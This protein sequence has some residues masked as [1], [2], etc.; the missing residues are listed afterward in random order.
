[1]EFWRNVEAASGIGWAYAWSLAGGV[2]LA[3]ILAAVRPATRSRLRIAV[4]LLL[5]SLGI[6]LISV[7]LLPQAV[8]GSGSFLFEIARF[9]AEI[10]FAL[11]WIEITS[12]FFFKLFLPSVGISTPPILFDAL[13]GFVYLAMLLLLLGMNG[14]NL[15]GLVATSAVLTGIIGFSMQDTLGNLVGGISLQAERTIT[16]G[17]WIR[18]GNVEGVIR[19]ARWRQTSIETRDGSMLVIPNTMLAKSSVTVLGRRHGQARFLLA[20]VSFAVDARLGPEAVIDLVSRA[21]VSA[22][23]PDVESTPPPVC[24]LT[25]FE[26]G[27][28][29][30]NVY[31]WTAKIGNLPRITSDMR[32]RVFMALQRAEIDLTSAQ[33]KILLT[34]SRRE[35][36]GWLDQDEL[37][38]RVASIENVTLLGV[39]TDSERLDLAR[40]L[41]V[42]P[43]RHGESISEQGEAADY[44]YILTSGK[45]SVTV[46]SANGPKSQVAILGAGDVFGEMGMMTGRLRTATVRAMTDVM[47]YRL[48]RESFR[49]TL[50]QRPELAEAI[51]RLLAE[52][53]E[54]L[55]GVV[56]GLSD[57]GASVGPATTPGELLQRIRK[58]FLLA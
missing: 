40:L 54:E 36:K 14:V 41:K 58:F 37:E 7:A 49:S 47:C 9:I 18:I 43:F 3:L 31:F 52:R 32:R 51:A 2:G 35:S 26:Q 16:V 4:V 50:Q 6:V 55:D 46:A 23:I 19:E 24:L 29:V 27:T 13:A 12:A 8:G 5:I 1:M 10:C 44:L 21:V 57:A 33:Q 15:S 34:P 11:A 42:A 25:A 28:A 45:A 56:R 30:Y 39:L 20:N 17:D 22:T 48:D 38:R 53:Q